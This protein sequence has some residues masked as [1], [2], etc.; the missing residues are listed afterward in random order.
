LIKI[1]YLILF[2][3]ILVYGT[4]IE[5]SQEQKNYLENK[6]TITMCVDPDWAPFEIINSQGEHEG[7]AADLIDLVTSRLGIKI[8]LIQTSTWQETLELSKNYTCDIL[9]F[10]NQTPARQEWL[11]FTHPLLKDPNVLVGRA[12]NKYIDDLSKITASIA[13]PKGTAMSELFARDF[14]NLTIIPTISEEEAFDLVENKKADLTLRSM[15]VTAYTIKKEGIFNLKII[16]QPKGYENELRMGVRKDEPI[17]KDIL[18]TA[19]NTI[20]Q[21][22]IDNVINNHVK[23]VIE[24]VTILSVALWLFVALMLI[25]LLVLLWNYMLRKRVQVEVEKNLN[26]QEIM[27]QQNKE[28]EVGSLI[29]NISHQWRDSLTN[30]SSINLGILAKLDLG[31]EL[32]KD[33]IKSSAKQ[34]EESI[35]FMSNTMKVFLDFYKPSSY[36]EIFDVRESIETTLNIID[37]KIKHYKVNIAINTHQNLTIKAI[38]N[39]WMHIWLNFINNSI[40]IAVQRDVLNPTITIDIYDDKIVFQDNCG[41]IEEN[42]LANLQKE[43]YKGLGIKMS[44]QILKKYNWDLVFGNT[45]KGAI[46]E[47]HKK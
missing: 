4:N 36:V 30:I 19:I 2:Y 43:N 45:E 42:I 10:V 47:I 35:T 14:P 33:D 18:N 21:K 29:G 3:Q 46:F 32:S 5:L 27:F 7:I 37:M 38:R 15:I 23:I 8:D 34:I 12:E 25:T 22:D 17:L 31:L 13:L 11:T 41:Q 1:I 24:N 44:K 40:N 9:S 28:A 26:Q 20:T 6:Q 16:G 39:E